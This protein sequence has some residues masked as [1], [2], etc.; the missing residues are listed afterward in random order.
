VT[1]AHTK[2]K[3]RLEKIV[4][5]TKLASSLV[6]LWTHD[7]TVID[8][9]IEIIHSIVT[10][11][12][13]CASLATS[14]AFFTSV[15]GSTAAA[16]PAT[17]LSPGAAPPFFFLLLAAL[18]TTTSTSGHH[19]QL[20]RTTAHVHLLSEWTNN[21]ALP[22]R[23]MYFVAQQNRAPAAVQSAVYKEDFA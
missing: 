4:R 15:F 19:K 18:T 11:S 2:G 21:C 20:V 7:N 6:T 13:I 9:F 23:L 10:H 14:S 17:F 5:Q 16:C 1:N 8:R 3:Q 22:P 12:G